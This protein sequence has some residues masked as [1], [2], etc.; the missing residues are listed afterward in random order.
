MNKFT[1]ETEKIQ[2]AITQLFICT[3]KRDWDRVRTCFASDFILDM[4]SMVGGEPVKMTPAGIVAAW[5]KGLKD[6][7]YIHHQIGNFEIKVNYK[8]ATVGC[9]GIAYHFKNSAKGAV[10]HRSFV[11]TYNFS[12]VLIAQTWKIT[13]MIFKLGFVEGNTSLD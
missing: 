9:Y 3:D 7:D 8:N 11:G 10:K 13:S 2:S 1:N 12:L 4:T 5:D 6:I